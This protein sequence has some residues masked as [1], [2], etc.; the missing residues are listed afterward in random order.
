VID[1]DDVRAY[2]Q[3]LGVEREPPSLDALFRLHRAQIEHVPYETTWIQMG[4][5][6]TVDRAESLRR[7][8]HQQTG[9]Y[10]FQLNGALSLLLQQLGYDVTLHVGGVHGPDGPSADLMENHLVL[11]VH[12][13]PSDANPQG[14]WYVDAGLGDALFEPL[15]VSAGR[16]AQG[17]FEMGIEI[18]ESGTADWRFHHHPLGSFTGMAWRAAPTTI[19]QFVP[20]HT[21]LS[22]S[23]DSKF[24]KTVAVQRRDA[25]GVHTM[26]G[27]TLRRVEAA[28]ISELVVSDRREWFDALGDIFLLPLAHISTTEADLLWDRVHTSHL[29]W[30]QSMDQEQAQEAS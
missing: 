25:T 19:D 11:Q 13:L 9:G 4:Q 15:P 6:W 17:P 22:T 26:R 14:T 16:Y 21:F 3:R 12:G 27:T 1:D 29:A 10:C 20:R 24:V 30:L 8:A 7:I 28:V 5:G 2:L 23:P 18:D